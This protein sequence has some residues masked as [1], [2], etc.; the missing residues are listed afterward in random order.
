MRSRRAR[1]LAFSLVAGLA[2]LAV[3]YAQEPNLTKEQIKEFLRTAKVVKSRQTRKGITS[4]WQLTLSNGELVH[5]AVFQAVNERKLMA[6]TARGMEL[7][8]VDSYRYNIAAYQLAEMIGLDDL[9]PVT[10]ERRWE[11]KR[12][13]LMWWLPSKM[14][15]AERV[16]QGIPVPDPEDWNRQVFRVRVFNQLIYDTDFNQTNLLIGE[17]WK[18]WRIDFTRAFRLHKELMKPEELERC[19]RQLLEKLKGLDPAEFKKKTKDYL[20]SAEAKA[21]LAR[22][23]LLVE[24]FEK[25]M[26]EKGESAV[27][28]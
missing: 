21:V 28:Y 7:N 10:V 1:S 14:D 3:A 12:G 23:D 13:A 25:L 27:L 26:A 2:A 24:H 15:D 5:D 11:G 22:R 6:P 18:V 17:D 16:K 19:D 20:T 4:P 8:F 9:L